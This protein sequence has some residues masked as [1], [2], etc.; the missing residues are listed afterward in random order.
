MSDLIIHPKEQND[1]IITIQKWWRRQS[2][3]TKFL[4]IIQKNLER[5]RFL[6]QKEIRVQNISKLNL[7]KTKIKKLKQYL[8]L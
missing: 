1:I 4:N 5:K 8:F 2:R 7:E 6:V 3:K